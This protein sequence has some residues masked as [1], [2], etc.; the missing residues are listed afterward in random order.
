MDTNIIAVKYEDNFNPRTFSG[1]SY[2]YFT[3]LDLAIGDI[4]Q[5]P[6]KYGA[7]IARVTRINILEEEIEDIKPYMKNITLKLNRDRYLNYAEILEDV[8]A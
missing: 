8:A 7:S 1:K 4:V 2:S 3:N 5:A 6:T